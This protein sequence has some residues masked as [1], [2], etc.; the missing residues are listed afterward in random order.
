M[1]DDLLVTPN[2]FN[3]DDRLSRAATA[4]SLNGLHKVLYDAVGQLSS[5]LSEEAISTLCDDAKSLE[6]NSV[7]LRFRNPGEHL[8]RIAACS[9][10]A[11]SARTHIH[12]WSQA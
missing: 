4:H 11:Q 8:R 6:L 2:F 3:R 9:L 12:I 1:A 10:T 7:T 5:D